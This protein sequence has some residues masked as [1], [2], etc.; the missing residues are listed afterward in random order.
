M[1]ETDKKKV[2]QYNSLHEKEYIDEGK[3]LSQLFSNAPSEF[4]DDVTY[5]KYIAY[6]SKGE[7]RDIFFR[8]ADQIQI[9][10]YYATHN[11]EPGNYFS[12]TDM[13][14]HLNMKSIRDRN[15]ASWISSILCTLAADRSSLINALLACC[16]SV[17]FLLPIIKT[18][19]V[20]SLLLYT[21]SELYTNFGIE[22]N[23]LQKPPLFLN[24]EHTHF[25]F[26][27]FRNDRIVRRIIGSVK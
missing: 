6:T 1:S 7:C 21:T 9:S 2:S 15:N 24:G 16:S 14:M 26:L 13:S 25:F 3:K 10:E 23:R 12:S 18:S 5:I 11:N 20:V 17:L 8:F 19:D 27:L 4:K 22:S